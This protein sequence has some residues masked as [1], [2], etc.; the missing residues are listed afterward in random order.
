MCF[1]TC[2]CA[3]VRVCVRVCAC[4]CVCVCVCACARVVCIPRS[5]EAAKQAEAAKR[6]AQQLEETVDKLR[7]FYSAWEVLRGDVDLRSFAVAY[8]RDP[9]AFDLK[10]RYVY[11]ENGKM[12]ESVYERERGEKREREK[13]RW[14]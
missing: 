6:D 13:V 1:C 10:L 2:V 8:V 4:V 14:R 7:G 3:C 12:K 11:T 5:E 9:A